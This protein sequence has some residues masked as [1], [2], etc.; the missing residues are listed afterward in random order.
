MNDEGASALMESEV[1]A[2]AVLDQDQEEII[3]TNGAGDAFVGGFLSQLVYDKPL[4][5]CIRAGH[6]AASV[7]IRRTGCTFPEKPDFR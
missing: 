6:Y 2:F 7:I 3:D 5:E 1:T 4:T